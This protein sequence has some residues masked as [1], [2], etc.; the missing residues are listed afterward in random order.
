MSLNSIVNDAVQANTVADPVEADQH[1]NNFLVGL[2]V[3]V[4]VV[5]LNA[6]L[7]QWLWNNS[8]VKLAPMLQKARWWDTL[9]VSLLL[10]LLV[11]R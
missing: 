10:M 2:L 6:V 7:G 1:K 3:A 4:I 8:L 11:P 5:L 9:A